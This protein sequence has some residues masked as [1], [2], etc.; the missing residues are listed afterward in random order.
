MAKAERSGEEASS[1]KRDAMV[2]FNVATALL[3]YAAW[4]GRYLPVRLLAL[5]TPPV[6]HQLTHL[7]Q[8]YNDYFYITA[9]RKPTNVSPTVSPFSFLLHTLCTT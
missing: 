6:T 8:Y 4:L 3:G 5:P 9:P 2:P 1:E 7:P